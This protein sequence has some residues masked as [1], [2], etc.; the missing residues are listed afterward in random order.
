MA[1]LSAYMVPHP[2]MIIPEV[3]RGSESIIEETTKAYEEVAKD[4]SEVKPDTIIVSDPHTIMYADYNHISPGTGLKETCPLLAQI[5][6]V[7]MWNMTLKR[8]S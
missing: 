6:S 5:I 4:I 3:G 1:I 8:L 2:P 7:L